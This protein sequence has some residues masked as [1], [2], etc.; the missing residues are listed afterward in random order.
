MEFLSQYDA[1]INYIP[2]N[3]NCIADALSHLPCTT[4][5]T[6]A[7]LFD[8][9]SKAAHKTSLEVDTN[10]LNTIKE[11]YLSD[12]FISK[13]T[14]ASTGMN[15]INKEKD[16]W[17]INNWL[18]IPN[19]K[20]ICESLFC[21]AHDTMGHFGSDKCLASLRN[22]FYWPHMHCCQRNKLRTMKPVGPLHLLPIPDSQCN[23]MAIYFIGPLPIDNRFDTIITFTDHLGSDI[24]II[25]TTST[26]TTEELADTFFDRW[27]CKNKLP[28]DIISDQDK[29]FMSCFWKRLH[30]LTGVKLKMSTAYHPETDGSSK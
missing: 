23:S 2:G 14:S 6:V 16:F 9:S 4:I 5:E 25:P 27:Y 15:I 28:L 1:S 22:S 17:F 10:V 20:H 29:L 21:L 13:L 12:P 11:G 26:L 30:T 7:S 8:N 19:I 3:K 18:V 24:Q